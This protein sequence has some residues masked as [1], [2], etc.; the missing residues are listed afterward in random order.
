MLLSNILILLVIFLL[1]RLIKNST[2]RKRL[3][4]VLSVLSVFY[5]QPI[6][7]IRNF[8]FWFPLAT[9]GLTLVCWILCLKDP[10]Q[11]IKVYLPD[12]LIILGTVL[13]IALSRI[14]SYEGVFTASRPP[15]LSL[16][17]PGI[18]I[19]CILIAIL[20]WT[21]SN[22][23]HWLISIVT[24]L[25]LITLISIKTPAIADGI[26][27][28]FRGLSGQSTELAAGTD[29]RWLGFS[30]I[31][32]RLLSVLID[33]GKGRKLVLSA[34]DF[35]TYV[36]FPATLAAGPIDRADHF[37]KELNH[38]TEAFS[39]DLSVATGRIGTG[40]FKK[41]ILSDSLSLIALSANNFA[42]FQ[43]SGW[44]WIAL[45]AYS[46]QLYFD[47]SGYSD[48]A[49]GLAKILGIKLPENFNHPYRKPDIAK[50]WSSW[51]ITLTQWIRSYVF[52]PLTR[53]LRLKKDPP[54]PQWLIILV[55]Q[56][57]TMGLIGLWHGVTFNFLIWGLWNGFG[58]FVHQIY[59]DQIKNRLLRLQQNSVPGYRV[60]SAFSIALTFGYISLGWVWFVL[61]QPQNA[62]VF[63]ARLFGVSA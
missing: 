15:L 61:P 54:V 27:A 32:F 47:F 43:S 29:L 21:G 7:P 20:F 10:S 23:P 33:A 38:E 30:Y 39:S 12:L 60:Y 45:I 8:D 2:L 53:K 55:T 50:F 48:I 36:C 62:L 14:F 13:V 9:V 25:V 11:P 58:L 5:L 28:F 63:I 4:L 16:S 6:V 41:F 3:L 46:F 26:S 37:S 59:A 35:I 40:L 57:V 49:I 17:L 42:S 31:A 51:H 44:A 1:I 56:F 19:L 22:Q 34:G 18:G 24:G 52:N